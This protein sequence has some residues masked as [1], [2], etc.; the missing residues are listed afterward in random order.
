ML[1]NLPR[2][3]RFDQKR[4]HFTSGA[5][6]NLRLNPAGEASFAFARKPAFCVRVPN[7]L[8]PSFRPS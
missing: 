5:V 1:S 2:Q 4:L 3:L 7:W 6:N 8:T